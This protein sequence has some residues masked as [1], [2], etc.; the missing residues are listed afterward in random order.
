VLKELGCSDNLC[1]KLLNPSKRL[2]FF[3]KNEICEAI[4]LRSLSPKAYEML[5]KNSILP[6]PHRTTLSQKVKHFTCAPGLQREFFH[7]IKLKMSVADDFER[8]CVLL[9]DEMEVSQTYEYC[10]R[11]KQMFKAHKKVQVVLLR[12]QFELSFISFF[13]EHI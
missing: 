4:L 8:Q 10:N 7:L 9:F 2:K 3:S 5:R 11:L 13:C 6:L 12:K 1:T